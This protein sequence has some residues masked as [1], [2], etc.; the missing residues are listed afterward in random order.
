VVANPLFSNG[1][2]RLIKIRHEMRRSERIEEHSG[3]R[4]RRQKKSP[5]TFRLRANP[6]QEELEETGVIILLRNKFICFILVMTPIHKTNN[7][8]N[9]KARKAYA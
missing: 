6:I 7:T 8:G 1:K 4:E 5:Q 3:V 9:K 2:T